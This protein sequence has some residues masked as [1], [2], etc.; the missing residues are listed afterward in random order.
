[1]RKN[2][3]LWAGAILALTACGGGGGDADSGTGG[4]GDSGG[5][6]GDPARGMMVATLNGCTSCHGTDYSGGSA[7]MLG[8]TPPNITSDPAHGI[9]AWSDAEIVAA[10]RTGVDPDGGM[11]CRSMP[12]FTM[13][14]ETDAQNL[15][16]YLR[17]IA[18][19]DNDVPE[20]T[21][22]PP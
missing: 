1:M 13:I 9:G 20:G 19:S 4:G 12:R 6:G 21:C 2:G 8:V 15:V 3:M 5:G 18:P 22:T 16:A 10:V 17:T 11:L 14:G 7:V